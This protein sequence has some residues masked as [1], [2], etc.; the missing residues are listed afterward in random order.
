MT[1]TVNVTDVTIELAGIVMPVFFRKVKKIRIEVCPPD[2]RVEVI[3]PIGSRL[4]VVRAMCI[5][6]LP[7]IRKRRA[8]FQA[9]AREPM[10]EILSRESHYL[11]GDRYLLEIV[12][13]AGP[14]HVEHK[15]KE[16]VLHVPPEWVQAQRYRLLSKWYREQ[17]R[18]EATKYLAKWEPVVGVKVERVFVQHMKTD[19]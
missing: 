4:D 16:I 12:E 8:E 10:R 11:W 18:Q 17:V 13:E 2:G 1:D 5:S 3:A 9:Q 19:S 6:A 14:A 7:Q 15:I